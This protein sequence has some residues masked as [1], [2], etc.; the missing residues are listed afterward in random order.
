MVSYK[1]CETVVLLFSI[2]FKESHIQAIANNY[3][4]AYV[5]RNSSGK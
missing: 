1:V 4:A 2:L 5:Y 3:K